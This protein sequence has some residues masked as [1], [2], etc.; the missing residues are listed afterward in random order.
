MVSCGNKKTNQKNGI[1]TIK[2][3]QTSENEEHH[4]EGEVTLNQQQ[5]D[6]QK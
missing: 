1:L 5:F 6:A 4:E 3:E 2:A